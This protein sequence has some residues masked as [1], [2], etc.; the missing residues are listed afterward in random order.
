MPLDPDVIQSIEDAV[1]DHKQGPAVARR[2]LAWLNAISGSGVSRDRE[3]ELFN[4]LADAIE[5]GST[6]EEL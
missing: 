1:R 6:V 2:M 4:A 3:T 5:G